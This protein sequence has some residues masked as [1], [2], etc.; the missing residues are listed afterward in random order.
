MERAE[1]LEALRR[2]WPQVRNYAAY[3][4]GTKDRTDDLMQDVAERALRNYDANFDGK[5]V[6]GWLIILAK[7]KFNGDY[8][9]SCAETVV[10]R[11][12]ALCFP[13]IERPAQESALEAQDV[14][15]AIRTLRP[16]EQR[17][18]IL[19]FGGGLSYAEVSAALNLPV[20]TVKTIVHRGRRKFAQCMGGEYRRKRRTRKRCYRKV[21]LN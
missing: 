6:K 14:R 18:L 15:R 1:F 5:S 16:L 8:S 3:L 13:R 19:I 12:H 2:E 21:L 7:N 10:K 9:R 4:C 17:T 11:T 20:N